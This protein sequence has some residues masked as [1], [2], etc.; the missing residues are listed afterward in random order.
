MQISLMNGSTTVKANNDNIYQSLV[1]SCPMA[2]VVSREGRIEYVNKA[3]LQMHGLAENSYKKYLSLL[4]YCLAI[5]GYHASSDY[6]SS[7][8]AANK[9]NATAMRLN[10]YL[11]P[12]RVVIKEVMLENTPVTVSYITDISENQR[13]ENYLVQSEMKYRELIN[14]AASIIIRWDT[15]GKIKFFNE[16]AQNYFGFKKHE[17]LGKNVVGTIVPKVESSGRDLANLMIEIQKNPKKYE[18]NENE[19]ITKDGK[20]VWVTWKN[21]P[22]FNQSGKLTE[23]LSVGIDCTDRKINEEKIRESEK[24][25]SAILD[26]LQDTYFR[27]DKKGRVI[28]V[29]KSVE[30]LLGYSQKQVHENQIENYFLKSHDINLFYQALIENDGFVKGL[31]TQLKHKDGRTVWVST[32]CQYCFDDY[33]KVVGVEGTTRNITDRQEVEQSLRRSEER[34]RAMF[35]NSASG[36]ALVD[37]KGHLRVTN[38]AVQNMLGYDSDELSNMLFTDFTHPED[39]N[40]NRDLQLKLVSGELDNYRMEKRCFR[41]DGKLIWGSVN[42]SAIRNVDGEVESVVGVL[43]DVT[44]RKNMQDNLLKTTAKFQA[45][46]NAISDAAIFVDTNRQIVMINPS[47]SDMFGYSFSELKGKSTKILYATEQDYDHLGD[48]HFNINASSNS[49]LYEMMYRNKSGEIFIGEAQGTKIDDDHGNVIGF[50]S[51]VRDISER[52]QTEDRLRLSQKIFEDTAKAILVTDIETNIVDVNEAFCLTLGYGRDEILGKKPNMFKSDYHGEMFYQQLWETLISTGSWRGEIYDKKKDGSIIPTWTT[53]SVVKDKQGEPVNYVAIMSDISIMKDSE[54]RLEQLAHFDQL[55][56]LPNRMVFHEQLKMAVAKAMRH[57]SELAVMYIDLDGFKHV[58][59]TL[60]HSAGDDLLVDIGKRLKKCLRQEDTVARLGG[61]EFAVIINDIESMDYVDKLSRRLTEELYVGLNYEGRELNVSGSVGVAIYPKDADNE[62]TLLR[63][64]DQA[65][66][67]AKKLGKNNYQFFNPEIYSDLMRRIH[68]EADLKSATK[69]GEFFVE[70]QPKYH[71]RNES[72]IGVEALI[73]WQHPQKGIVLPIEFIPFAEDSDLIIL[74][75]EKVIEEV[76]LHLKEQLNEGLIP[77]PVAINLSARQLRDGY[78]PQYMHNILQDINIP[79]G[80]LE[81]EVTESLLME[82]IDN[83]IA[84]LT[85]L[86]EMGFKISIDDFGTGYSSLNYLK[87]L[88]VDYLKI[89]RSFV[90][91]LSPN[92]DDKKIV[93]AILSMAHSLNLGVIAEGVENR[94]QLQLLNALNC[95]EIQGNYIAKP[96][97][98][99]N[100]Q[101]TIE[102]IENGCLLG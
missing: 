36:I 11:F 87:N 95:H 6:I 101:T 15:S 41:K 62:E 63:N 81:F 71:I 92:S 90:K 67:H 1:D 24:R 51:I 54:K 96:V 23:I 37:L 66:Y 91:D 47:V 79:T 27:V 82:D 3:C 88:P 38:N 85:E 65:M 50:L 48:S 75:G 78:F 25:L 49:E 2:F 35:E 46:F 33:G 97:L 56:G 26:S 43:E 77:V 39:V 20:T 94:H 52:K 73:R 9:F 40:L 16:F 31:R 70:Y 44:D 32:N 45:I 59:D 61:D 13:V 4:Q 17:I 64:A 42:V 76:C 19:N 18:Y 99:R 69:N 68:L 102:N 89:D 34:F 55:T 57:N 84:L 74:I 83:A 12:V 7:G 80:L 10:G 5:P 60:G 29:S 98:Y 14:E 100:L 28:D 93:S 21:K 58:N 22:V 8:G 30:T 86:K 72:V 53:I